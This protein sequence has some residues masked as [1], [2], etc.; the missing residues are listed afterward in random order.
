MS[1]EKKEDAAAPAPA[2]AA[3]AG[4]GKATL[5]GGILG[6]LMVV[7]GGVAIGIAGFP[8]PKK[9]D[10][11]HAE[12][13]H[14]EKAEADAH[15]AQPKVAMPIPQ[16]VVNLSDTNGRHILQSAWTLELVAPDATAASG[17]FNEWLP[18]VQDQMI[19]I[20]SSFRA[21]ELDGGANKEFLQTRIKDSLNAGVFKAEEAKVEAVYFTEF[22]VQ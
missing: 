2:P 17:K 16:M 3:P 10:E 4:G 20:L 21:F 9:K 15:A 18:R 12:E 11:E 13:V 19:K 6:A 14:V 22:V 5:I 1:D 7:G 8:G